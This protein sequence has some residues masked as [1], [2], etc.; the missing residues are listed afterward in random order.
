MHRCAAFEVIGR[1]P[2]LAALDERMQLRRN[3]D[4]CRR[5]GKVCVALQLSHHPFR[6]MGNGLH[7]G[8]IHTQARWLKQD[9]GGMSCNRKQTLSCCRP[10]RCAFRA[11]EGNA[12]D[13]GYDCKGWVLGRAGASSASGMP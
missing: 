4:E 7:G 2:I 12:S 3:L 1:L 5:L 13:R 8:L 10:H 11:A 9:G 6:V